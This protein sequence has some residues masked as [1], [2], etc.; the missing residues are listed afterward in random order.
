MQ[1]WMYPLLGG[2]KCLVSKARQTAYRVTYSGLGLD[3]TDHNM[4]RYYPL[5][6]IVG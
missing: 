2:I 1:V 5:I 3:M 6:A 4:I